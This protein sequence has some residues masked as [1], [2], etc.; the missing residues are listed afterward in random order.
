MRLHELRREQRLAPPP[1]EVFE[2][3]A[4]ARNLEAITPPWLRF[5]VLSVEPPEIA[6]GTL[7]RYRLRLRG[8]PI[9]WLTRIE[10]WS[11][12]ERFIDRQLRGPY[13]HWH[14]LH[15]FEPDGDGTLMRDTVTYAIPGGPLGELARRAFVG[16]DLD[17]I[18]DHR[19]ERIE[20][21]YAERR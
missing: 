8:V 19:R 10:E 12:G 4:D 3:F 5:K 6:A 13:R 9:R 17:R 15:E 20:E 2:F 11:P 21:L 16:S 1:G 7:I 14:H 18:F